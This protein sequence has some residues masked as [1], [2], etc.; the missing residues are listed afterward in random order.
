MSFF[1]AA[2]G[3]RRSAP[4]WHA[5][6][7]LQMEVKLKRRG[8]PSFPSSSWENVGSLTLGSSSRLVVVGCLVGLVAVDAMPHWLLPAAAGGYIVIYTLQAAVQTGLAGA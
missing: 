7:F 4:G 3:S 2:A 6:F 5:V 8:F 1:F